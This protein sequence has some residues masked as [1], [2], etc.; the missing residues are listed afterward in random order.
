MKLTRKDFDRFHDYN[1]LIAKRIIYFGSEIDIEGNE[2]GVDY[3][4]SK[5]IIKNLIYLDNINHNLITIM[6]NSPGGDWE[7][8]IAIYDTIKQIKS[9]VKFIGLGMVRSMGSIVIQACKYRYLT[10]NC[11]FMIHDGYEAQEG[12]PKTVE[13]W[14]KYSKYTREKMYKIYLKQIKKKHPKFTLKQV[15]DMCTHD[16]IMTAEEAVKLGL[17]DKIIK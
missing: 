3:A 11:D 9:P 13:A 6:W 17:A 14:A 12:E 2:N 5:K 1:C 16:Y 8:G 7:R 15:E 4:S 10:F